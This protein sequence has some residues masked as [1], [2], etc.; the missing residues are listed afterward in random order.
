MDKASGSESGEVREA[1]GE[2]YSSAITESH[3]FDGLNNRTLFSHSSRVCKFKNKISASLVSPGTS[4]LGLQ[5]A[6]FCLHMA[7]FL[8]VDIPAVFSYKDTSPT[9][10]RP[11]LK[12]H[13]TLIFSLKILF[14][15]TPRTKSQGLSPGAKTPSSQCRGLGL[16]PGQ[17]TRS[18]MPQ[19]RARVPQLRPYSAK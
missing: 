14:P 15:G 11:H 13:I 12:S 2:L 5:M 10:L 18:H 7:L 19:Q 6:V 1:L 4:L 17:G 8:Y 9:T 3:R 16:I